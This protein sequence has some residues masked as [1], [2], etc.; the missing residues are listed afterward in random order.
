MFGDYYSIAGERTMK[1]IVTV[2]NILF[3]I[4]LVMSLTVVSGPAFADL[5][6]TEKASA[7][8]RTVLILGCP[9]VNLIA[10]WRKKTTEKQVDA[11][12]KE[13]EE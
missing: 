9:I 5:S 13:S 1:I 8:I 6:W 12:K 4:A 2:W 7:V 3:V 11:L 10:L